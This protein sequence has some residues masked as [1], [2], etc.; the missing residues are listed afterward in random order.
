MTRVG[1]GVERGENGRGEPVV[2]VLGHA[3][4]V[5][6]AAPAVHPGKHGRRA[7]PQPF[8]QFLGQLDRPPG[9]RDAGRSPAAD[10]AV[11]RN[12]RAAHPGGEKLG[13]F[14]EA[15]TGS[16]GGRPHGERG[17]IRRRSG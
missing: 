2:G 6:Q 7:E 16:A 3:A 1:V 13:T 11:V 5:D 17:C 10:P 4:Q 14:T 12:D 8:G 15:L 9:Q